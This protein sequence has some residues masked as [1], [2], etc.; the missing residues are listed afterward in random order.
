MSDIYFYHN[1]PHP[2]KLTSFTLLDTG[3]KSLHFGQSAQFGGRLDIYKWMGM[4]LGQN[5]VMPQFEEGGAEGSRIHNLPFLKL[6]DW[7][8]K[9]VERT[10]KSTS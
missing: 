6:I 9:V 4:N 8:S 7:K 1:F 10:K 2:G 3:Q 5:L